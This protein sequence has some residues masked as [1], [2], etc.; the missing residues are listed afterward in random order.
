MHVLVL[1]RACSRQTA[2][3]A[4]ARPASTSA[5]LGIRAECGGEGERAPQIYR[6]WIK[7]TMSFT[8][9]MVSEAMARARLPPSIR[10]WSTYAWSLVRRFISAAIGESFATARSTRLD[11]K[12]E[13]CAPP[14][15]LNT[16]DFGR[17]DRAA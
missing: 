5:T 3:A 8:A 17:P 12:L 14:N 2:H 15:S 9:L 6:L 10:T 1:N 11:L 16:S 4:T 13:N 7:P